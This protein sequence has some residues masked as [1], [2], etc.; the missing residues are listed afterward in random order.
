MLARSSLDWKAPN[1]DPV[2][3]DRLAALERLRAD[4]GLIPSLKLYY[5]DNPADFISDWGMTFDPRL[6]EIGKATTIPFCLFPKQVRFVEWLHQL[7]LNRE[8]GLAEKSRDMGVSWLCVGFAVWMWL[9]HAGT[10]IGFGSRKE[11]YVDKLGDP[12]SLFWKVRQFINLLPVEFQPH[13]WDETKHAPSMRIMNPENDSVIVGEAGDN[14]GR[15]N[16]TSLYFKDESA[17]YERPDAID[18]ALSMTSNCKVDV[19]TPNGAGN[20]F[21]RRR[22]SGKVKVFVFDW[23][24]DPRKSEDWYRQQCDKL[25]PVI[26][27]QEIDR[28]YEASVSDAF[29]PGDIVETAQRRGPA[30]IRAV[31][32]IR[33]GIDVAR[34]GDDKSVISFRKGRVL[35]RQAVAVKLDV[36]A[37]AN[38]ART[39]ISLLSEPPEQIAVDTIGLGAGVAD[40]LRGW[41]P[42]Q[43]YRGVA[44]K[45]VVDVN[46]SLRMSNGQ[47]YNL[48][49]AMW[50]EMREWLKGASIP[51]DPD[52]KSDLT[53][54]RYKYKGGE[55]LMEDKADAKA[56]G[57]KS[58]DRADSLAL[59]FAVPTKV[60]QE[61]NS[62]PSFTNP[63]P[64]MG[65]LG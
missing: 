14:I 7:W 21:Y 8:D 2:F 59:T 12:K 48:R 50:R 43:Q 25:D 32:G 47:D 1:Y 38:W 29:V 17:F 22:H 49:S 15:G 9:F 20:P 30:D 64:S 37:V 28:N 52:L 34:F 33:V 53:S 58:P 3:V 11:E 39:E 45:L 23:R 24:D 54:L 35:I 16:R 10:V 56:R 13:G 4:P 42:D 26:V 27:A 63:L 60:G 6:A 57:M 5:K 18:A 40:I 62:V 51:R 41:Y 19:S 61:Y 31:G 36:L 55:M 46:S 44:R 65:M